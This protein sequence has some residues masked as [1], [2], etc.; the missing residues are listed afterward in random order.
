MNSPSKPLAGR[1]V[2]C[3]KD[4]NALPAPFP[5]KE[6]QCIKDGIFR[7]TNGGDEENTRSTAGHATAPHAGA[8]D[9]TRSYSTSHNC[10]SHFIDISSS[11]RNSDG[12]SPTSQDSAGNQDNEYTS[13]PTYSRDTLR[14]R[15]RESSEDVEAVSVGSLP[16]KK[17]R[18]SEG[19]SEVEDAH[20]TTDER[21]AKLSSLPDKLESDG[22]E[23]DK[24]YSASTAEILRLRLR[25]AMFKVK[26]D[27]TD[28]PF[29]ELDATCST[30]YPTHTPLIIRD[31]T[32]RSSTSSIRS[33]HCMPGPSSS[34]PSETDKNK[35]NDSGNRNRPRSIP[36]RDISYDR[37]RQIQEYRR[38][39]GMEGEPPG[40]PESFDEAKQKPPMHAESA[41]VRPWASQKTLDG[42]TQA[43]PEKELTSSAVKGKAADSLLQLGGLIKRTDDS[44]R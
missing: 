6:L 35:R 34:M 24:G 26:T 40:T 37:H 32:P 42:V 7:P 22:S 15:Q 19:G 13:F 20:G 10:P 2:L 1:R 44:P 11:P 17:Q 38:H 16:Y 3:E 33:R 25:L 27:Q 29:S 36:Q 18:R 14:K 8:E 28:K 9:L 30:L 4:V 39:E 43:S 23:S 5:R 31:A 12:L 41:Y 21:D